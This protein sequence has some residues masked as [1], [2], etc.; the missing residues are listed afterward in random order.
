MGLVLLGLVFHVLLSFVWSMVF[1]SLVTHGWRSAAA[2]IATGCGAL[3]VPWIIS[4]LTG[5]GL[6]SV[7]ALGDR[8]VL[9]TVLAASLAVGL[10]LAVPP[11]R[12]AR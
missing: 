11:P 12:N 6:A 7:L 5:G 9:A 4:S 10:R 2:A 8:L 3:V 1:V